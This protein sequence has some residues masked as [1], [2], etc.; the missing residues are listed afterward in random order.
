MRDVL[1]VVR[2]AAVA[3]AGVALAM[4]LL[5]ALPSCGDSYEPPC[6]VTSRD[7]LLPASETAGRLD[8]IALSE[9]K[10]GAV[11]ALAL[12]P[13]RGETGDAGEAG[14]ASDAHDASDAGD[15]P[16]P[17]FTAP[18]VLVAII[19]AN[20]TSPRLTHTFAPPS[21]LVA[22]RDSTQSIGATFT[23]DGVL[24]HW[25]ETATSTAADGTV[26]TSAAAKRQRV[27]LEGREAPVAVD[28]ALA[29][30]HCTIDTVYASLGASTLAIVRQTPDDSAPLSAKASTRLVAFDASGKKTGAIDVEPLLGGGTL[31]GAG[32]P[33][34]GGLGTSAIGSPSSFS[35][36]LYVRGGRFVATVGR[37]VAFFDGSL[38]VKNGPF[39]LP[40]A[41]AE[42]D[43]SLGDQDIA[44][45]G[46]LS[47]GDA[48]AAASVDELPDLLFESRRASGSDRI[49][50]VRI[51]ASTGVLLVTRNEGR[52]GILHSVGTTYFSLV[53]EDGKK[54]GG[55]LA[56][57]PTRAAS[58]A[59]VAQGDDSFG[60]D[61]VV[62][63]PATR[64]RLLSPADRTH[65][66]VF[67]AGGDVTRE[68][69]TCDP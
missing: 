29:C 38:A 45:I 26:T 62:G 31:A 28:P 5:P 51:S 64:S 39:S 1:R 20:A 23:G 61:N 14:D 57:P 16:P 44:W 11:I 22:R 42:L 54:I 9:G 53:G 10:D 69:I 7:V 3:L 58:T 63:D 48:A 18:N 34:S 67:A 27:D 4:A 66:V 12:L 32:G 35:A 43:T 50:P 33:I 68:V 15:E 13:M 25:I 24:F 17:A 56:L 65:F 52:V 2:T 46:T 21:A 59:G 55:D 30:T 36:K 60:S 41:S 8:A 49:T 6:R 37:N 47:A 40:S 19:D